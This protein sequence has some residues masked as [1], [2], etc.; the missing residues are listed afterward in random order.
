MGHPVKDRATTFAALDQSLEKLRLDDVD[1]Y[2]IYASFSGP[3]PLEQ[4][5]ALFVLREQG[6]GAGYRFQQLCPRTI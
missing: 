4:W 5:E 1:L 6:G 2:L 3:K